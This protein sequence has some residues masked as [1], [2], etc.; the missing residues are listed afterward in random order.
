[1][2]TQ[3]KAEFLLHEVVVL[4][5]FSKYMLDYLAREDIFRPSGAETGI[6][7]RRRVYSFEDLVLL[8][9]LKTIC[10]SNGKI[11]HLKDSLAALRREVGVIRPGQ[12][13][14]QLLFVE[15]CELCTKTGADGG[16]QLRTG[17]MTFGFF[18][19]LRAVS[20]E[21]SDSIVVDVQ[22][23]RHVLRPAF[24][25]KAEAHR[26]RIWQP[27]RERRAS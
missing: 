8:R 22:T 18:V 19:D 25:A 20:A 7:G 21:L 2:A 16:K 26:Q 11:R 9:A 13:L 14:D 27:I 12:R 24:A 17:Q 5:G 15:G 23:G 4:T 6:R 10:T 3:T 1:M